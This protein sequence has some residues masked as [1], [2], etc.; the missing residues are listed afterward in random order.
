APNAS[1]NAGSDA[2]VARLRHHR[3][4]DRSTVLY[5]RADI[6]LHRIRHPTMGEIRAA[7]QHVA[8]LARCDVRLSFRPAHVHLLDVGGSSLLAAHAAAQHGVA[9]LAADHAAASGALAFLY[10]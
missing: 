6:E 9:A 4:A 1:G 8:V 10:F 3:D 7:V 2:G 5:R